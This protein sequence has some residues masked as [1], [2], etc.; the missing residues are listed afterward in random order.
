MSLTSGVSDV[1]LCLDSG[2]ASLAAKSQKYY[3]FILPA[4]PVRW[5]GIV[6]CPIADDVRFDH[7]KS[8]LPSF[9]TIK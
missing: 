7:L 1:A 6:I 8:Y 5:R 2:C 4:H 3:V 9:P